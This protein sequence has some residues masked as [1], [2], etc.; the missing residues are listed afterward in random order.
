MTETSLPVFQLYREGLFQ[1]IADK[2]SKKDIDFEGYPIFSDKYVLKGGDEQAVRALFSPEV[3]LHFENTQ[4]C[5]ESN[6]RPLVFWKHNKRIKLEHM[7]EFLNSLKPGFK[8]FV[9][10]T[11]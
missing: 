11:F 3:L 2:F 9:K 8:Q 6:G 4:W 10:S 7:N 5:G 1:K